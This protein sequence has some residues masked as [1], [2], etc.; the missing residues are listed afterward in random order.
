MQRW[1]MALPLMM[2]LAA[3]QTDTATEP[4]RPITTTTA[5]GRPVIV[6]ATGDYRQAASGMIFPEAL[7]GY[8]RSA[9]I[10]YDPSGLDISANYRSGPGQLPLLSVYVY[11]ALQGA[12]PG[13][14]ASRR[15]DEHFTSVKTQVPIGNPS[16]RFIGDRETAVLKSGWTIQGRFAEYKGSFQAGAMGSRAYLFCNDA[17]PWVVKIRFSYPEGTDADG[18]IRAVLDALPWPVKA[19]DGTV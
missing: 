11:P 16:L 15:C 1:I 9:V 5:A 8:R 18:T 17:S 12:K 4:A 10:S 7:P 13:S 6:E 14:D 2:G 19:M 3:C